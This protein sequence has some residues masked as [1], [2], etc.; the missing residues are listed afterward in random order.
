MALAA[1]LVSLGW[2]STSYAQ[3]PA[4]AAPA[5]T[6]GSG[7][8]PR[9]P[10]T[11]VEVDPN[12][13]PTQPPAEEPAA[14]PAMQFDPNLPPDPF[15]P[16]APGQE[17]ANMDAQ[18][19]PS[20]T[21]ANPSV[22]AQPFGAALASGG[23]TTTIDSTTISTNV[24]QSIGD[25]L[26]YEP[27]IIP[28]SDPQ[29]QFGIT[30]FNIRGLQG[31]RILVT[32]D[33]IRQPD[34]LQL[35]PTNRIGGVAVDVD[36]IRDI[37]IVRGPSLIY[38]QGG[39]GGT[40]AIE[41]KDPI[42]FLSVYGN[43][44]YGGWKTGYFQSNVS[45]DNTLYTAMRLTE[46]IE[47]MFS[48]NHRE[49]H[50]LE[51]R[52]SF[53]T[54]PQRW[55]QNYMLGKIVAHMTEKT[56]FR[57]TS[58]YFENTSDTQLLD[59]ILDP[60]GSLI[61]GLNGDN[62][63]LGYF[64]VIPGLDA[65]FTTIDSNVANNATYKF[66]QSFDIVFEDE[67]ADYVQYVRPMIFYQKFQINES[68]VAGATGVAIPG[69]F[70]AWWRPRITGTDSF[71][72]AFGPQPPPTFFGPNVANPSPTFVSDSYDI[73]SQESMGGSI[74]LRS[75]IEIG[76]AEHLFTYGMD[77]V[78]TFVTRLNTGTVS[79][80]DEGFTDPIVSNQ[81]YIGE[82][83]PAK[84]F[85]DSTIGRYGWYIRDDVDVVEDVF[86]LGTGV[87]I[88]Y[89]SMDVDIDQLYLNGNPQ[90]LPTD[91][92]AWG[93][94]PIVEGTLF[95]TENLGL[96]GRYA[97]GFRP[98]PYEDAGLAFTNFTFG[99]TVLPNNNLNPEESNNFD[100]GLTWSSE[101]VQWYFSGY[102][103]NYSNYIEQVFL[104]TNAINQ[105][106]FQAQN[107]AEAEIYGCEGGAQALIL[108]M[109]SNPDPAF[110]PAGLYALGN[111]TYIVGFNNSLSTPLA[112]IPPVRGVFGL[113]LQGTQNRWGFET[114][115]TMVG[116]TTQVP[117][118]NSDQFRPPGYATVDLLAYFKV[119]DHCQVNLG[120]FNIFDKKYWVYTNMQGISTTAFD[121]ERYAAPG[122]NFGGTVRLDF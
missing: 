10:E 80:F 38:G 25:A 55:R 44:Y 68:D 122:I 40:V 5:Q 74:Q 69:G 109:E 26:R 15:N 92:D 114:V 72:P 14:P 31:N 54:N 4:P 98:P 75:L 49:G 13:Q 104:G 29:G 28:E 47:A 46:D 33:M 85:P 27:G 73:Y 11:T 1:M 116:D 39:I 101:N 120:L 95:L 43:D 78:R 88:D 12:Q 66:R 89:W 83:T 70:P 99:Y 32:E 103:N 67:D 84:I 93:V 22:L 3:D 115:T 45:V 35:Q 20:G 18:G 50:D 19:A 79:R 117:D 16:P 76:D 121:L 90:D 59:T 64:S 7:N 111:V 41:T 24:S 86:R 61:G 2:G 57:A 9:L 87:R 97:H 17:L 42:D 82:P 112:N 119:T 100:L 34:S 107:L 110:A 62:D 113:R 30:S 58:E 71:A 60:G 108:G 53:P 94:T 23:T 52:G 96:T 81:T 8:L 102:Y 91:Q 21:L 48:Y 106:V 36:L 63:S 105:Q 118:D 37:T 51:S 65:A 77:A 6:Q 56:F